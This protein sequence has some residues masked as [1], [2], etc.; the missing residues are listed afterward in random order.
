MTSWAG[1]RG[2]REIDDIVATAWNWFKDHPHGY[3]E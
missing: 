1:R 3:A 2:I